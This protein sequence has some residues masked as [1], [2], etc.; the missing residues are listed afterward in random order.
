PSYTRGERGEIGR[1]WPLDA[2]RTPRAGNRTALTG[3]SDS[4]S[5]FEIRRSAPAHRPSYTAMNGRSVGRA[6]HCAVPTGAG[7]GAIEAARRR[8]VPQ[9]SIAGRRLV[10][11]ADR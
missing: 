8:T 9:A 4:G 7:C 2:S 3:F 6:A 5:P 10:L 11:S 1:T